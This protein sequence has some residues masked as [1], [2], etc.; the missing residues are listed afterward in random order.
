[1]AAFTDTYSAVKGCYL[2]I[3]TSTKEHVKRD[4][5]IIYLLQPDFSQFITNF[6]TFTG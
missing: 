4:I 1:M 3:N 6:T 2:A 5:T